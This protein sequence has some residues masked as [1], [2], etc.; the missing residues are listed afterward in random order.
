[1]LEGFA[2]EE[3]VR[4]AHESHCDLIVMGSE[5]KSGIGR[6][7]LGSVAEQV[8]RHAPCPVLL[9]KAFTSREGG[10]VSVRK[11][12]PLFTTILFPT[13]L[14]ER[15]DEAFAV[16]T[17]L[18]GPDSRLVV[19]HVVP[20]ADDTPPEEK[21][22]ILQRL[23]T[24]YPAGSGGSVAY[25]LSAGNVVSEILRAVQDSHCDLI[26]MRSRGRKGIGR[27]L[28]GSVAESVFRNVAVPVVVVH[29][30]S[31]STEA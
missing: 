3:I 19:Q 13:D 16:A 9:C 8:A 17:A 24:L 11:A 21:T 4:V 6:S 26:V 28:L 12:R 1:M 22:A 25:R 23:H 14:S 20:D 5:G 7:L 30:A 18:A 27:L 2:W 15:A 29:D 31:S 10:A